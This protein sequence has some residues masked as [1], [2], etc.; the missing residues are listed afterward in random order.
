M[1][2]PI[3]GAFCLIDREYPDV[4]KQAIK[5]YSSHFPVNTGKYV[6]WVHPETIEKISP[7]LTSVVTK[8]DREIPRGYVWLLDAAVEEVEDEQPISTDTL[9]LAY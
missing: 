7:G 8:L 3:L 9:R 1:P 2:R 6:A 4:I 5:L